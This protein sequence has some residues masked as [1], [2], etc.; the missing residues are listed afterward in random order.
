MPLSK[1]HRKSSVERKLDGDIIILTVRGASPDGEALGPVVGTA[2]LDMSKVH[3]GHHRNA[4]VHGWFQRI[5]DAA[6]LPTVN[7]LAPTAGMKLAEMQ[8]L[9]EHY[10]SGSPEWSPT[11]TRAIGSDETLC[12]RVLLEEFPDKGAERIREY[13]VGLSAAERSAILAKF[14]DTADRLRA[15]MTA[16]VD[17]EALLKD[18]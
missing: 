15:E 1:K 17:T 2:S 6:A 11:R 14:K 7:G 4:E 3:A 9:C 5:G 10:N 16:D 8:K 13:V 18:L 12:S